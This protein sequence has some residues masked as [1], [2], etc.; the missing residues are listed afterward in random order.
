MRLKTEY[1]LSE[2][3][4]MDS[5]KGNGQFQWCLLT[6]FRIRTSRLFI[7]ERCFANDLLFARDE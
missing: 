5:L 7:L 2:K 3:Y 1:K 6:S 4:I